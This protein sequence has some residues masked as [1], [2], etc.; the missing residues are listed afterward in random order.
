MAKKLI[1]LFLLLVAALF[2]LCC[3]G[4]QEAGSSSDAS[5]S[6]SGSDVS[7]SDS[8][9]VSGDVSDSAS[10]SDDVSDSTS[11]SISGSSSGGSTSHSTSQSHSASSA[12]P[13][14]GG[15]PGFSWDPGGN[16]T[17]GISVAVNTL[18]GQQAAG[19]GAVIDFGNATLGYVMVQ[20]GTDAK[21]K[22]RV[23]GP[24]GGVYQRYILP[25]A[26]QFYG[27]PLQMGNGTYTVSVWQQVGDKYA[28]ICTATFDVSITSGYTLY[29]NIFADY[30]N[31]S[32]AVR[33]GFSLCM[34]AGSDLDKVKSVYNWI[35]SNIS[36]DY[37]KAAS[38][39]AAYVPNPDATLSSRTGICFDYACLMATM[40][41]SQ[42]IPTRI[43]FGYVGGAFHAWNDVYIKNTGWISVGIPSNGGWKRLDSTFGTIKAASYLENSANYTGTEYF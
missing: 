22:V 40:L 23:Q 6:N 26:G 27:I 39:S 5:L 24:N 31:S 12:S 41:R 32:A 2:L 21:T 15:D 38:V 7:E 30:G 25:A 9:S 34:N 36:Y 3:C 18:S 42:G 10:V 17:G 43:V 28:Q 4:T 20:K 33:K 19:G 13:S 35:I 16:Y 29:P 37:A 11:S 8:A 14:G 1:G